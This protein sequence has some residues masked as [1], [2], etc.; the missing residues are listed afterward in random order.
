[1]LVY[2]LTIVIRYKNM[3]YEFLLKPAN[4]RQT[5]ALS[6]W[7][8]IQ[9]A[10]LSNRQRRATSKHKMSTDFLRL[11]GHRKMLQITSAAVTQYS[12]GVIKADRQPRCVVACAPTDKWSDDANALS[13][14]ITPE[15]WGLHRLRLV[16]LGFN[17]FLFV[18]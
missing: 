9:S 13:Q 2:F 11:T 4:Y 5:R 7:R 3:F 12:A 16:F 10:H 14:S 15:W 18:P 1:M 17:F 8:D 6:W